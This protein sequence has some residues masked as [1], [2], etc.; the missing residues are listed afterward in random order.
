MGLHQFRLRILFRMAFLLLAVATVTLALYL[1]R[2]EKQLN[3]RSY[4]SSLAKTADEISAKLRH[5]AGQL[6]LLNPH[7]SQSAG[8]AMHPLVLPFAAIDFDDR[9]KARQAVDMA[10]CEVQYGDSGALCVAI[11]NK[12]WAGGF[13]Y[14]TGRFS[15][16][17][18]AAHTHGDERLDAAHRLRLTVRWHGQQYHWLAPYETTE[19]GDGNQG[20]LTGFVE[21]PGD[22][23]NARPV[24]DFRGWLWRDG[25]CLDNAAACRQESFFSVRLPLPGLH[26]DLPPGVA[27]PWPPADLDQLA[28]DAQFLPPG[29]GAALLDSRQP[30]ATPPFALSDLAPLLLPGE[31][32][33]IQK[34]GGA[35]SGV[36]LATLTGTA[37]TADPSSAWVRALIRHL[38]VDGYEQPVALQRQ[39]RTP[40]G[41][42]QLN[43]TGDVRSINRSLA[44]VA[45][46]MSWFV[47]AMLA[48]IALAWLVIEIGIIRRIAVLTRRAASV[49]RT[50]KGFGGL[51]QFNLADLRGRDELGI[52]ASCLYDLLQRVRD[53]IEREQIRAEQ[54]KDRWHAVGHEIMSPL[55]SLMALHGDDDSARY[56]QRMQ[57]A[58]RVLY[59]SASPSE[60]FESTT[61]QLA[62][63]DLNAF[64]QQVANNAPCAGIAD[65]LYQRGE[66]AL[67]VRAD[68]YSLEDVVTHVLKNADRYRPPGSAIA[69]RVLASE[70][71]VSIEIRNQGPQIAAAWLDKIFEYGVSDQQ[72]A[73]A[74]GSRGQGLF[75]A[76][77]YMAKMGGTISARNEVDGVSFVLNLPR[78]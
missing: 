43:L 58:I 29:T 73:A 21:R 27:I 28:V 33:R 48:A 24:H 41:V 77:T 74:Q 75:V 47:G 66:E 46:R 30:G 1:L 25:H 23:S 35:G 67:Q 50:V 6:A 5:P 70:T 72:D 39:I 51:D 16:G 11:G 22:Y 64:L 65:V 63:L 3:Y 12:P 76:K 68:E 32:L 4:Q 19:G 56:I 14:I 9:N 10:G 40:S 60:A 18:L 61:L 36:A 17:P 62:V 7:A 71:Q 53:D 78:V 69:L 59:G 42:Y 54:E 8:A 20:R 26:P 52:L 44:A 15:S 49:S 55:Q 31:Q 2:E 57:Q 37:T 34:V 45:T 13:I 38:R